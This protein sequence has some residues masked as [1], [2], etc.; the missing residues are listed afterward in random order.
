ML[1]KGTEVNH[2]PTCS[3]LFGSINTNAANCKEALLAVLINE[4]HLDVLRVSETK[5]SQDAPNVVK[6]DIASP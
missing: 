6:C 5:V 4:H 2:G 1:I 3:L